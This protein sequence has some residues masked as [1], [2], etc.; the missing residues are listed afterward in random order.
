[1]FKDGGIVCVCKIEKHFFVNHLRNLIIVNKKL[2]LCLVSI[3]QMII[4]WTS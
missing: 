3:T 4:A 1:M 2:N